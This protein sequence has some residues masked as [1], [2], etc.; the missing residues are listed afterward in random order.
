MSS[1]THGPR[2]SRP[3]AFS[4][5]AVPLTG[6]PHA[7]ILSV[8]VLESR[9][10]PAAFAVDPLGR[11][12]GVLGPAPVGGPAREV[13][14]VESDVPGAVALV[15]SVH[16]GADAVL[17]DAGGD[18]LAE[19]QAFLGP[20]HGLAG[21]D[22]VAHGAAGVLDLGTVRLDRPVL[23]GLAAQVGVIG[24]A[25]RPGGDLALYSCD[26]AAGPAGADFV[27]ALAA[28]TGRGVA[29]AT[30]PVGPAALGGDWRL[31]VHTA[32]V[33]DSLPLP[34]DAARVAGLLNYITTVVG[35]VDRE[36]AQRTAVGMD[37]SGVAL[38]A[39]GNMFIVDAGDNRILRVDA[40]TGAVT[41]VAGTGATT[42]AF[43][44]GGPATAAALAY[45]IA[46]A[47][48]GA[49]DVFVT[50]LLYAGVRRVD[51]STGVITTVAGTGT[52]GYSGD[53]GPAT[54]AA[55]NRPSGIAADPA[56]DLFIA[57]AQNSVVREV[58]ASTG[59]IT[60]VAGTGP[61]GFGGDGGPAAAAQL[62]G[63]GGLA[64][65]AAGDLFIADGGNG[66]VRE[67]AASTG[68]ITTV[69]GTGA[70]GFGGDGG[71]AAAAQL[72]GPGGLAVDA[73]GDLFIADVGNYRLREVT[74]TTGVISTIAGNGS[75]GDGGD[76]GPATA[77]TIGLFGGLAAD[78]AGNVYLSN[79]L[80]IRRVDRTTDIITTFAGNGARSFNFGYSGDGGPGLTAQLNAPSSVAVDPAG[81]LY[82]ADSENNRIRKV[83]GA[84]GVITTVA[85]TGTPGY[86]GDGGPATAA[87]LDDPIGVA[88]DGF[89]NLY[90]VDYVSAVVRKVD[91]KTG[92]ITTVAGSTPGF[93]GDGGPAT[94]AQLYFAGGGYNTSELAFDAAGDLFIAD[95]GNDRIREVNGATGVITTVA[96]DGTRAV[97]NVPAGWPLTRPGTCSSRTMGTI[98][99]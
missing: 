56:G 10:T 20:R 55:I 66:R 72:N 44:D 82:I 19:M 28:A 79:H 3:A 89:G 45:P 37:P 21:V 8:E 36:G 13:V 94:A 58:V 62:N 31:D 17:L 12:S 11:V 98:G 23:A 29:A 92:T 90:I 14:F 49:G 16:P 9:T 54:A 33:Q 74:G 40:A 70:A 93:S 27:S 65:D 18:G 24:G 51:A 71:P 86:S 25:I 99:S 22:V 7:A 42:G 78:P 63:P 88:L 68:V 85:G 61:A 34:V 64:V 32:G 81:N 38:D 39:A 97:M 73:A 87:Q 83:D 52:P 53:G 47:A 84:T 48:D 69:A 95:S 2:R 80:R 50:Q 75:Y 5:S 30:H 41:T 26:V 35:A 60:T 76:G 43:G 77:A 46:V 1:P 15:E 4:R 57:D 91:G 67:V 96:G 59:V 6:S